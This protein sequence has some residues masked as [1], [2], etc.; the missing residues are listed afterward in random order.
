V[1]K[2]T[3]FFANFGLCEVLPNA[4]LPQPVQTSKKKPKNEK[5]TPCKAKVYQHTEVCNSISQLLRSVLRL[6]CLVTPT[7]PRTPLMPNLI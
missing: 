1:T 7:I 4:N 2:K 5:F 3:F 6:G